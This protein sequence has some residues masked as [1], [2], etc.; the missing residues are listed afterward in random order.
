LYL[1]SGGDLITAIDGQPV[2]RFDD[3]LVYLESNKSPGDEVQLT[4]LRP[5]EGEQT[6]TLT[7]GERPP[8][9]AQ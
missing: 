4:I 5:N 1:Q 2:R 8:R 3:L 9:L 7:L 6:V